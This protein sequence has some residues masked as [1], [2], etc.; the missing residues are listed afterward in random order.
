MSEDVELKVGDRVVFGD[1]KR[2]VLID[3]DCSMTP[4]ETVRGWH[5]KNGEFNLRS[6]EDHITHVIRPYQE[7]SQEEKCQ[8]QKDFEAG[9][10]VAFLA[11]SKS[12]CPPWA[13][14]VE[15][16]VLLADGGHGAG[17]I[18]GKIGARIGED[19]TWFHTRDASTIVA[20]CKAE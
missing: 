9:L 2:G 15:V 5:Y 11:D 1:G 17:E 18:E 14:D 12:A 19:W 6:R 20:Y 13:K 8:A 3:N 7:S 10:W 16:E 4:Y